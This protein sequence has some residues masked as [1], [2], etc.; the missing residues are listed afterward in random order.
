MV[1]SLPRSRP[2]RGRLPGGNAP[3]ALW[4]MREYMRPYRWQLLFMILAAVLAVSA[5]IAIPLIT[6]SII[7][8]AVAHGIMRCS[9]R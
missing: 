8:G 7:D 3:A 1:A 6:K 5:E 9:C 2:A 4:R